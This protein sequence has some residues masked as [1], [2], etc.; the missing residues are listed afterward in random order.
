MSEDDS[1]ESQ[2]R[3]K[4]ATCFSAS[5]ASESPAGCCHDKRAGYW[6]GQVALLRKGNGDLFEGR[7]I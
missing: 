4:G 1:V 2:E 6:A 3:K 5:G 7:W